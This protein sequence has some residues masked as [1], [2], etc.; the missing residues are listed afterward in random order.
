MF[1]I[2]EV[3]SKTTPAKKNITISDVSIEDGVFTDEEGNI[4]ERLAAE[5]DGINS[6]TVKISIEVPDDEIE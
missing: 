1:K 6:F 2:N 4:A 5:L 3:A